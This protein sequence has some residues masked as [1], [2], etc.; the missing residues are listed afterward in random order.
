VSLPELSELRGHRL[1]PTAQ[2]LRGMLRCGS[3]ACCRR[4]R[5]PQLRGAAQRQQGAERAG[6][7]KPARRP[8]ERQRE[9]DSVPPHGLLEGRQGGL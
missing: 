7:R 9:P 1:A 5:G 6:S 3:A 2:P 4:Q 8:R